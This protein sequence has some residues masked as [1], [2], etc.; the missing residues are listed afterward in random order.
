MLLVSQTIYYLQ[1][2]KPSDC[3]SQNVQNMSPNGVI[4]QDQLSQIDLARVD[5]VRVDFERVDP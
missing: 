3:L 4:S 1:S 2:N 5:I